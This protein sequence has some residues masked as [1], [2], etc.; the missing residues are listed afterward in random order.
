MV[1]VGQSACAGVL[2]N[3]R[4]LRL[5]LLTQQKSKRQRHSA[6]A[7]LSC[8]QRVLENLTVS[9][10]Y[11]M[12]NGTEGW[13][14]DKCGPGRRMRSREAVVKL[15]TVVQHSSQII[16]AQQQPNVIVPAHRSFSGTTAT[17]RQ[18]YNTHHRSFRP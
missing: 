15:D 11:L 4:L 3:T 1:I 6:R 14:A 9:Q 5:V 17:K 16:Q 10:K 2:L 18:W 12:C 8:C 7:L 13:S